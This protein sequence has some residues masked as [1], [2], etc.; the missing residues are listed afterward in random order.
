[1]VFTRLEKIIF[2]HGCFWHGHT[3]ARGARVP[4]TNTSYWVAK[5]A[6]NRE[7]DAQTL[8]RLKTAGWRVLVVWECEIAGNRLMRRIKR[9]LDSPA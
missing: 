7:R 2:V 6:R 8:K 5:V 9:F 4:K 1:M 3:C